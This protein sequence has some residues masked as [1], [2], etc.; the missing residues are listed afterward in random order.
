M[1]KVKCSLTFKYICLGEEE[2]ADGKKDDHDDIGQHCQHQGPFCWV[3]RRV[4][5]SH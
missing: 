2:A 3:L 5:F 4:D 1:I